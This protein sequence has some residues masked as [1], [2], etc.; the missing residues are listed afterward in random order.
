MP[1][2]FALGLP[3]VNPP[4]SVPRKREPFR[5]APR[6]DLRTHVGRH[7]VSQG[8]AIYKTLL[9]SYNSTMAYLCDNE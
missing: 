4:A 7:S 3:E 8:T 9:L 2:C 6:L 1:V 5:I